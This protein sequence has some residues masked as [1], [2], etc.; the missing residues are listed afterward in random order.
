MTNPLAYYSSSLVLKEKSFITL[1]PGA[2]SHHLFFFSTHE[3]G[4]KAKAFLAKNVCR[5]PV[6]QKF[7][8]EIIF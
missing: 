6:G 8:Q 7:R 4:Q 1:T 2:H 5:V 3:W